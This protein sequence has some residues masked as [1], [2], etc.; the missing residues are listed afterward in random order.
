MNECIGCYLITLPEFTH[1]N[2]GGEKRWK[3]AFL[4]MLFPENFYKNKNKFVMNAR[5]S[6]GEDFLL[7]VCWY[8]YALLHAKT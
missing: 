1:K 7:R 3:F 2:G 6:A 8:R 4:F 5:K